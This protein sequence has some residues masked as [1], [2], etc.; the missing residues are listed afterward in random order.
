MLSV[1]LKPNPIL[2]RILLGSTVNGWLV[3]SF[4]VLSF[5][6]GGGGGGRGV[7]ESVLLVKDRFGLTWLIKNQLDC[8]QSP[9][10]PI[11]SSRRNQALTVTVVYLVF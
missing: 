6:L 4:F 8:S 7:G 2:G 9:I 3:D 1:L 11:R 5:F 10:F